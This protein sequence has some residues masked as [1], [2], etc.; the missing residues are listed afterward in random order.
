M[1][2]VAL[3]CIANASEDP[4]RHY[5]WTCAVFVEGEVKEAH[6]KLKHDLELEGEPK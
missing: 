4:V 5:C 1:M 2:E 6:E 3:M